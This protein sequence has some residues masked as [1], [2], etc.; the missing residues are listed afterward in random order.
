[1]VY[2][3]EAVDQYLFG[4][5]ARM[6]ANI[7]TSQAAYAE[8]TK[9]TAKGRSIAVAQAVVKEKPEAQLAELSVN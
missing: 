4:G 7:A 3:N 9:E 2:D 6:Q 1:M 5:V 8:A